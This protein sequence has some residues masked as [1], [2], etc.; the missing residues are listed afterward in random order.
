MCRRGVGVASAADSAVCA[1][2]RVALFDDGTM[3]NP[4]SRAW[5][6]REQDAMEVLVSTAPLMWAAGF[7][8]RK[9]RSV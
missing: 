7:C 3:S 1:D 5:V 4:Q 8:Q 9:I 2:T 6:Y